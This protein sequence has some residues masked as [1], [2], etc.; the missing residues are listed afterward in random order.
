MKSVSVLLLLFVAPAYSHISLVSH[1]VALCS[2]QI[3][4][5]GGKCTWRRTVA[6][7]K[8]TLENLT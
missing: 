8:R 5:V 4:Q 7:I 6:R 2:G 3:L 1:Q